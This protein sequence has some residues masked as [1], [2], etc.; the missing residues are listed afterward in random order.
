MNSLV[1]SLTVVYSD[2]ITEHGVAAKL[3]FDF[4]KPVVL[5]RPLAPARRPR[6]DKAAVKN[7]VTRSR[8][9]YVQCYKKHSKQ[10]YIAT[11]IKQNVV[12]T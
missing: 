2:I 5:C 1:L 11:K 10:L 3:S 4:Q 8:I 7:T 12:N 6:L 9:K